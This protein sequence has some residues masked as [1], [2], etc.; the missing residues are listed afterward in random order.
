MGA[1][2][3]RLSLRS[4][5][6]WSRRSCGSWGPRDARIPWKTLVPLLTTQG[7][8]SFRSRKSFYSWSSRNSIQALS[9]R[10]SP[11]PWISRGTYFSLWL[12]SFTFFSFKSWATLSTWESLGQYR[13]E[14]E[15][16]EDPH[17][18]GTLGFL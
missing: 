8:F 15:I 12:R 5:V 4:I 11:E 1:L 14:L 16:L 3:T 2:W 9:P 10:L 13:N 7:Q 17:F 6:R 18:L